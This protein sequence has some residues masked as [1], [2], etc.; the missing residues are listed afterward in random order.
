MADH[1][2]LGTTTVK[3]AD[4]FN[5]DKYIAE[6]SKLNTKEKNALLKKTGLSYLDFA[7]YTIQD[8]DNVYIEC[9]TDDEK[10]NNQEL[11]EW[12]TDKFLSVMTASLA[13]VK[14]VVID[15]EEGIDFEVIY[16][17]KSGENVTSDQLIAMHDEAEAGEEVT[18]W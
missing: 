3:V 11:W 10:N 4:D 12:I 1:T 18:D 6:I 9:N 2:F 15:P 16:L 13:E 17:N 7:P 5:L 14:S 8:G